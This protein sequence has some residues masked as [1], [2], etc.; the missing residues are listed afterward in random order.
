MLVL[1]RRRKRPNRRRALADQRRKLLDEQNAD[2][3]RIGMRVADNRCARQRLGKKV[4][5]KT[6]FF[7]SE[8]D[9]YLDEQAALRLGQRSN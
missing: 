7:G 5:R 9:S 3:Q 6:T 4:D 1:G 2:G 8:Q